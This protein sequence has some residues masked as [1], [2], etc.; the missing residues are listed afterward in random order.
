MG[1]GREKS[2]HIEGEWERNGDVRKGGT[3]SGLMKGKGGGE[4]DIYK[5]EVYEGKKGDI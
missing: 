1:E 2:R 4:R 3:R 5:M